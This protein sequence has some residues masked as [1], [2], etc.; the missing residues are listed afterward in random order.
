MSRKLI[1]FAA[2]TV[3]LL[4][5]CSV[6]LGLL[7][8]RAYTLLS[9]PAFLTTIATGFE[10]AT[11]T[12]VPVIERTPVT[13]MM[14]TPVQTS[15]TVSP[16]AGTPTPGD[17][18]GSTTSLKDAS[19]QRSSEQILTETILPTRDQRQLA[20]RLKHRGQDIPQV[21]RTDP[22]TYQLEDKANF[23][24]T[25]NGSTPPRQFEVEASLAYLTDHS[26]WWVQRGF[27]VDPQDLADSAEQFESHTYPTNREFFGSEWIPGID[28]D[29]RVHIFL[30]DVPGVAGYFAAANSYARQAE[31]YSNEREMF[32]INLRSITPGNDYF[33]SVL[34]HEFQHMIHWY[35]DRNEDTWVNEGMS[36]LA[37][38]INGYGSSSFTGMFTSVPDT[39]LNSW[40]SSPADYGG[41]F[42]FMA[43]FLE[44]FGEDMTKAVIAE[45]QN[46]ITGFDTVLA[47]H[48]YSERFQNIY[49]DF[50]VANYLNNPSPNA[51]RWGYTGFD[52]SP[53]VPTERHGSYPVEQQATVY[54][55]GADYIELTGSE[56][57]TLD[58]TGST[59]VKV[60]DNEPHSGSFQWYSHRGDD[61]NTRLTR[62]FDLSG[63][64]Q[65]TLTYQ[66]WFDIE[67]DWDYGYVE[68]STD[69]GAIWT[70]LE[71]PYTSADNP[72][73]NAY[74][75]GYTGLSGGWLEERLDLTPYAGQQILVRFEYVTDDAVN[76]PGWTIDDISIPEIN[77]FDDVESGVNGWQAE[78]FVRIDNVLPQKFVVQ[79]I[80]LGDEVT[81]RPVTLD[82]SNYGTLQLEGLGT[83]V[84]KA[85]LVIS[86]V[87]PVTTEPASYEYRVRP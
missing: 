72:S 41:S 42:L 1:I 71:T 54:Q 53:I 57:L 44:R 68:V 6:T 9:D 67:E 8:W 55:Y 49:A 85:V 47:A 17:S 3:I 75:P 15:S 61:S 37:S 22:P 34:A 82:E 35:E 58:F 30:G 32:F 59:R 39:Q 87:S 5:V 21:V 51:G 28:G 66:T 20:I 65:A 31:P 18:S 11:P 50:L 40:S 45:P 43:Y 24:V 46:G 4:L 12:P 79:V 76:Q 2:I 80:E 38:L 86:G 48:G 14:N 27:N 56:A 23:W 52:L 77:F 73:G 60:V 36:E 16:P 62:A 64:D 26:A 74:G 70:I 7:G 63:V 33:D 13:T 83:T 84:D 25:D 69:G 81:V 10:T 19:P 29:P 78:G